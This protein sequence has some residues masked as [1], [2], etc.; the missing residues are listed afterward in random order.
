MI[1]LFFWS[2]QNL[3]NLRLSCSYL[4]ALILA[5]W[6]RNGRVS[7]WP[8]SSVPM[9]L[10]TS[11]NSYSSLTAQL[12]YEFFCETFPVWLRICLQCRRC[13]FNPWIWK[14]PWRREWQPTPVFLPRESHGQRRVVGY[15]PWGHKRVRHNST[16]WVSIKPP[17]EHLGWSSLEYTYLLLGGEIL[18]KNRHLLF[19]FHSLSFQPPD[20]LW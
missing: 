4:L 18:K 1:V 20:G 12:K 2:A 8:R 17:L 6:Y 10:S 11:P 19:M 16:C 3:V 9:L 14:I 13:T 7:S 15:S 5:T